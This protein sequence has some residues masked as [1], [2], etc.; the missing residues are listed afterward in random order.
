MSDELSKIEDL[1]SRWMN[2]AREKDIET[3]IGCLDESVTM[4]PPGAP[5]IRGHD[6]YR[7]FLKPVFESASYDGASQSE[8]QVEIFGSLAI[9]RVRHT[10]YMKLKEGVTR[11]ASEGAIQKSVTT[12]DYMDVLKKQ[13]DGSWKCL[14]HTWQEV[15]DAEAN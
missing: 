13:E 15:D 4:H 12:S 3:Y 8:R 11:I 5:P 10:M 6:G 14:V 2:A 1:Y 7:V 9:V